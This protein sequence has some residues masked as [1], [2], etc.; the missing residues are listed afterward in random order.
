MDPL[1][2]KFSQLTPYQF[3]SNTPI[4]ALDLDGLESTVYWQLDLWW[5]LRTPEQRVSD[6]KDIALGVGNGIH[7]V[8]ETIAPIRPAT[9]EEK[10]A[11]EDAGGLIEYYKQTPDRLLDLPSQMAKIPGAYSEAWNNGDLATKSELAVEIISIPLA[12]LKGRAQTKVSTTFRAGFEL[13]KFSIVFRDYFTKGVHTK[14]LFN[15]GEALF[16]LN[17]KGEIAISVLGKNLSKKDVNK[18]I[19]TALNAL[20]SAEFRKKMI[21]TIDKALKLPDAANFKDGAR[22]LKNL[23]KKLEDIDG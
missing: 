15:K 7:S 9:P 10:Q 1:T 22:K 12:L 2:G 14:K 21:E 23:K 8:L 6:V 3:A 18:I 5:N 16:K 11:I 17:E 4:V 20:D 13:P 19:D